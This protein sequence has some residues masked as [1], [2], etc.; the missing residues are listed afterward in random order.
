MS[1]W[2]Y[3]HWE[4]IGTHLAAGVFILWLLACARSLG[5]RRYTGRGPAEGDYAGPLDSDPPTE[6]GGDVSV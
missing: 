5:A 1:N 6:H 3:A 2:I 4:T